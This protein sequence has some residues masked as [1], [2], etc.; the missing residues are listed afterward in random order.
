MAGL[1]DL[2]DCPESVAES[3][4]VAVRLGTYH[5][6]R[7]ARHASLQLDLDKLTGRLLKLIAVTDV[8]GDETIDDIKAALSD[9][10]AAL[11]RRVYPHQWLPQPIADGPVSCFGGKNFR[12]R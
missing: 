3:P 10:G 6:G 2:S 9:F 4:L 12:C 8:V 11:I 1:L 5:D 7:L